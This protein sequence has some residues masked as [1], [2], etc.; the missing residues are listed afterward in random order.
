MDNAHPQSRDVIAAAK[1]RIEEDPIKYVLH[2]AQQL[3][4]CPSTLRKI[5]RWDLDLLAYKIQLVQRLQSN[6]NISLVKWLQHEM[7]TDSEFHKKSFFS[8]GAQFRWS[9]QVNKQKCHIW[10]NDNSQ[11]IGQ[12]VHISSKIKPVTMLQSTGNAVEPWLMICKPLHWRLL[13]WT[14]F[15]NRQR[16]IPYGQLNNKFIGGE[17]RAWLGGFDVPTF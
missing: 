9:G 4:T 3:M 10:N 6:A 2:R 7:A 5:K 16:H 13:M 15:D 8:N 17:S 12:T 14:T 11:A 1:Q